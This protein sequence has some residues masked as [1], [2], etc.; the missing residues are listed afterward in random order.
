[1]IG[2]NS[3]W[4]IFGLTNL[5]DYAQIQGYSIPDWVLSWNSYSQEKK[6]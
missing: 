5:V 4:T 2:K 1:M 3:T 6:L